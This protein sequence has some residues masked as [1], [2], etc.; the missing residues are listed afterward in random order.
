VKL[1]VGDT[2][3]LEDG[4]KAEITELRPKPADGGPTIAVK[5][6]EHYWVW[7]RDVDQ[8]ATEAL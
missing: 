6:I 4:K 2:I 1:K 5:V 7:R 3:I 8:K